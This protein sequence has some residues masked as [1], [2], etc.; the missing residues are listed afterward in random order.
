MKLSRTQ[1]KTLPLV[2][3]GL[4]RRE[5][6]DR[7]AKGQRTDGWDKLIFYFRHDFPQPTC[8]FTTKYN[9]YFNINNNHIVCHGM[10][11]DIVLA[12]RFISL[13]LVELYY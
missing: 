12:C 6:D 10:E 11:T 3:C 5:D 2:W 4:V 1:T 7:H 9:D 13:G 8:E